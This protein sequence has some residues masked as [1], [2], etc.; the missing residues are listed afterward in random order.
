MENNIW[1]FSDEYK[2]MIENM[3]QITQNIPKFDTVWR[4]NLQLDSMLKTNIDSEVLKAV[5]RFK[6]QMVDF[7]RF[8]KQL[9]EVFPS[10]QLS[11]EV[12]EFIRD[13][14]QSEQLSEEEFEKK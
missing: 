11:A 4:N 7:N 12:R 14:K 6:E 1:Q 3:N 8:S 5:T 2:K 10:F 13:A 9:L